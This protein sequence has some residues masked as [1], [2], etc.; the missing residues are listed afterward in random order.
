MRTIIAEAGVNHNGNIETAKKLLKK[1][2][3]AG[4]DFVK[5]RRLKQILLLVKKKLNINYMQRI[6]MKKINIQYLKN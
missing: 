2:A 5:F 6:V 4:A 1:A 3:E